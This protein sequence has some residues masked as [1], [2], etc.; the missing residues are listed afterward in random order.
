MKRLVICCDGTWNRPD[1]AHVTNIEKIARTIETDPIDGDPKAQQLVLYLSGVGTNGY[2]LDRLLGGAFGLGLFENISSA[3][4]FLALNYDK[5]DEIFVFGF[6]RG[7]Y[8]ARSLVGMIGCV[9]L[10]TRESL[11]SGHLPE[12]VQ[13]YRRRRPDRHTFHGASDERFREVNSHEDVRVRFLGVFDTVGALG[14]PGAIGRAHQFHDVTLGPQVEHARHAV[15]I[16]EHRIKF[17]PALWEKPTTGSQATAGGQRQSVKQVWFEGAHSDVGGGYPDTGLSDTALEWMVREAKE[18]GLAF[19]ERLLATYLD[20]GSTAIRHES[21]TPFYR[22]LNGTS[23]LRLA[24]RKQAPGH[25]HFVGRDRVLGYEP[26]L[27]LA[28]ASSA[29]AHHLED[30]SRSTPSGSRAREAYAAVNVA[31]FAAGTDNFRDCTE[32]VDVR[33]KK[34][35]RPQIPEQATGSL[36]AL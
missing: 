22:M 6:S 23:R 11:I 21:V 27:G 25:R 31:L 20:S 16:D 15:A 19:D 10:L 8:T 34:P 14:V 33:P 9:G 35:L 2:V 26:G 12:A 32:E 24:L 7:A 4:R 5:H 36:S 28:I 3:Y 17:E 1:N 18:V 13:R 30:A 29:A